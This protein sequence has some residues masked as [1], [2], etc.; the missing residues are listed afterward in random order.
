MAENSLAAAAKKKPL[1]YVI[2]EETGIDNMLEVDL[3]V[4]EDT[5]TLTEARELIREIAWWYLY[6]AKNERGLP[7]LETEAH[8]EITREYQWLLD[9]ANLKYA[10]P[11]TVETHASRVN[12]RKW[13]ETFEGRTKFAAIR[14]RQR[15][16]QID[17]FMPVVEN[18][19]VKG[20]L[21][22]IDKYVALAR[23][24]MDAVGYKAPAKYEFSA[25]IGDELTEA[26][27]KKASEAIE[28]ARK[29]EEELLG[30]GGIVEGQFEDTTEE[31]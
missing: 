27:K 10:Q 1:A 30:S 5:L 22:A 7:Y 16:Q 31:E 3:R 18:A 24:D 6:D 14:F 8:K 26:D 23:L 11:R 29:F 9:I 28:D 25:G 15:M 19:I 21:G 12:K 4:Y 13:D 20:D 2:A 17:R